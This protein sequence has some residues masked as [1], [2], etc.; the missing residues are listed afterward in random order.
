MFEDVCL[1]AKMFAPGTMTVKEFLAMAPE[2]PEQQAVENS[3]QFLEVSERRSARG[4][5]IE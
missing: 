3:M 1:N 5:T 2:P 4:K